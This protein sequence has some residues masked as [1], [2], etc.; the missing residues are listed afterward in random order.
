MSNRH[1]SAIIADFAWA[2]S[3]DKKIKRLRNS[4][5]MT[6]A[7]VTIPGSEQTLVC[8]ISTKPPRPFVPEQHRKTAFE[9]VHRTNNHPAGI[10][11]AVSRHSYVISPPNLHDHLFRNNIG[12][13]R[14][15]QCTEP[16]TILLASS[17]QWADTRMSYLHQTSTTIC[18]GTTSKNGVWISAPNQQP[19]C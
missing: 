5:S 1:V 6:V 10:I 4:T 11:L 19:S 2:Q 17:W 8:H 9:S 7:K 3:S 14:L 13:R 15:N 16:T 18:S 12:K